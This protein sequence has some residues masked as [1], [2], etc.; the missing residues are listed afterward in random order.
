MPDCASSQWSAT[1]VVEQHDPIANAAVPQSRS[2]RHRRRRSIV[3][4]RRRLAQVFLVCAEQ[5]GHQ[6]RYLPEV[7]TAD[8]LRHSIIS[9]LVQGGLDLLTVAHISRN[10]VAMVKKQYRHLLWR[11]AKS[12]LTHLLL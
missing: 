6:S 2:G 5:G 3:H 7:A 1:K 12:A 10:S 4:V 9:D 8:R 11:I